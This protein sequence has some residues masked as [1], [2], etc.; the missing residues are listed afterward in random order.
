MRTIRF[1]IGL[2]TLII[3]ALAIAAL[4]LLWD[5]HQDA[6]LAQMQQHVAQTQQF[7]ARQKWGPRE[8]RIWQQLGW[9]VEA[10]QPVKPALA[11]EDTTETEGE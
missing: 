3:I 1:D 6:Q 9:V 2:Q 4:W 7:L 10:T 11:P 5:R 8:A